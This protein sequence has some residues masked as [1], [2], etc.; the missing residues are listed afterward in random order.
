MFK[1]TLGCSIVG[2]AVMGGLSG[3][4]SAGEVDE[5]QPVSA[6]SD[7]TLHRSGRVILA[8]QVSPAQFR[9]LQK[10]GTYSVINC[11]TQREIDRLPFDQAALLGDLGVGYTHLPLGGSDGYSPEDVDAFAEA[12][13]AHGG[14]VLVHCG[15]GGRVRMLYAAYLVRYEG[16][17]VEEARTRIE[18]LGQGPSSLERLLG[19][20]IRY[21]LT[22]EPLPT[23]DED[24][25]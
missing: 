21:E 25:S 15:S 4:G 12:L 17:S 10:R 9:D 18:P 8:G 14:D 13:R 1:T 23:P 19:E 3:C 22:G 20:R 5:A 2:L 6:P 11:R 24:E 7:A 16:L